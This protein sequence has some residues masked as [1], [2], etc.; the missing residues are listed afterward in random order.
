VYGPRVGI[1]GD[2]DG[3]KPADLPVE[4]PSDQN[5][6]S[7]TVYRPAVYASRILKGALR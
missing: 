4:Q 1:R 2:P 3:E 6:F 5:G 7:Q